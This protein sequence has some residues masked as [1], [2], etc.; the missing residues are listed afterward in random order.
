MV[1]GVVHL[2]LQNHPKKVDEE[3]EAI[4]RGSE[5]VKRVKVVPKEVID[6]GG[7]SVHNDVTNALFLDLS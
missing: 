6:V 1:V 5:V 3:K 4:K 2:K 7:R